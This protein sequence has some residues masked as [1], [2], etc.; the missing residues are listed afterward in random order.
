MEACMMLPCRVSLRFD[1]RVAWLWCAAVVVS[2]LAY[3]PC[4][5]QA[6]AD[7]AWADAGHQRIVKLFDF[8]EP[9]NL[10]KIPKYWDL[11]TG[12]SFPHYADGWFDPAV[13]REAPPSFYLY[14][15]GRNVAFRYRGIETRIRPTS[16]YLVVGWIKPHRLRAG[17]ATLTAY[18]LDHEG[19]PLAH[20]QRQGRLVGGDASGDAWHRVEVFLPAG[21]F[22][23]D[24][25][26]LTLWVEQA[27]IWDPTP[28]RPRHIERVDVHAGAW[29]DDILIY[30]LPRVTLSTVRPGNTF[31]EPQVPTLSVTVQDHDGAGLM[32]AFIVTDA[33]GREV[34]R[35]ALTIPV[36]RQLVEIPGLAPGH[37]KARVVVSAGEHTLVNRQ[38]QFAVLTDLREGSR[39]SSRAFG[40][41]LDRAERK[42]STAD[43]DLIVAA[44]LGAVKIPL[45][46][47]PTERPT[48]A[49]NAETVDALLDGLIRVRVDV[50]GVLGRLPPRLAG[51]AEEYSRS[52]IDILA[53]PVES[54]RGFLAETVAPY[55]SVL[56]SWQIGADGD[57]SLAT[58]PRLG[59]VLAAVRREMLSLTTTP[60]LTAPVWCDVEPGDEGLPA[61]RL[62]ITVPGAIHPEHIASHLAAFED[63]DQMRV[64][65]YL[66]PPAGA[67]DRVAR[68][69]YWA[70]QI[71]E[72]RHAGADAVY[73]P[74]PWRWRPTVDGVTV[75]PTEEFI[76]VRT[77][78][79]LLG[80]ARPDGLLVIGDGVRALIFSRGARSV[81]AVWD[82]QA[83]PEGR[84]WEVQLGAARRVVDL[85]GR[86]QPLERT[87][88]GLHRLRL[89]PTPVFI[90]DVERWLLLFQRQLRLLPASVT[91]SL[92]THR[93]ELVLTNPNRSVLMGELNLDVPDTWLVRPRRIEFNVPASS[94]AR[95]P[96]E[97]R[98]SHNETAG[99]K[100][101][102]A[103]VRV[104]G[105]RAYDMRVPLRFE[106]GIP[107]VDVWGFATV[108]ADRVQ[109]RHAVRNRSD[110][111]LSFRAYAA[112]P[113]RDQQ[114]KVI[115][116]LEPGKTAVEEFRFDAAA[117]LIG[118]PVRLSL[119]EVNGPR[120]HNLQLVVP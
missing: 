52:L 61:H 4:V 49:E 18:Y 13:G 107:D 24:A 76:V 106:L 6:G 78:S 50:T 56:A 1:R 43:L 86:S 99:E 7:D 102:H 62:S 108:A 10:G 23:A 14:L 63:W 110:R 112:A 40:V 100:T 65:A 59:D 80:D 12:E 93:H 53:D 26:G 31:V 81:L 87:P 60:Y 33:A 32:A 2:L 74:Q 79:S 75:E 97:L 8:N 73:V 64:E 51:T 17:R 19:L 67:Y 82:L 38:A 69:G 11:F 54:W 105:Q 70:A 29:F 66:E 88:T 36:D 119:R 44:G 39:Y 55:A 15:N 68:L 3:H 84:T 30:R 45:W 89:T 57:E 71:V 92:A 101:V 116:G 118:R 115:I 46:A 83:P 95:Y 37:Y 98:Y 41:V 47:G 20:T 16:D 48:P 111:P 22:E 109:I 90:T 120:M 85:W 9:E 103:N 27:Q 28:R 72:T 94:E 35:R 91:F 114:Y 5:A 96:I 117:D 42:G 113:G 25:L 21:P 104:S 58:D 77:I 34:D